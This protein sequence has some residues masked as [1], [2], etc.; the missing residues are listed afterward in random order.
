MAEV[1]FLAV[2]ECVFNRV[3][4]LI[5][6]VFHGFNLLLKAL[7]LSLRLEVFRDILSNVGFNV[8]KIIPDEFV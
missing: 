2:F 1:S 8:C 3:G 5:D 6:V 7:F 4:D